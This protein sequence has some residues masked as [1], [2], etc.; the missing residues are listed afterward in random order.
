MDIRNREET[1]K[2]AMLMALVGV[3]ISLLKGGKIGIHP[4]CHSAF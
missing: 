3:E 2:G 1:E 4:R